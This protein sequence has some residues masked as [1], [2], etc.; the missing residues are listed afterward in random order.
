MHDEYVAIADSRDGL[1]V[2]ETDYLELGAGRTG[3]A[4]IS[5]DDGTRAVRYS[6]ADPSGERLM[7]L[8][9]VGD[10]TPDDRYRPLAESVEWLPAE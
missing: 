5:F 9:C 8:F 7:A 6:F 2:E 3:F 1:V 10:P 4:D